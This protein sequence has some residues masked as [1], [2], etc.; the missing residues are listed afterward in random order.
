M[1]TPAIWDQGQWD[2]ASWD[3]LLVSGAITEGPDVVS[4]AVTVIYPVVGAITEGPDVVDG[5][6]TVIYPVVGNITEGEDQVVGYI[7]AG[8]AIYG[9]ITENPDTVAGVIKVPGRPGGGWAPQFTFRRE[10]EVIPEPIVEEA[11]EEAFEPDPEAVFI[12]TAPPLDPAVERIIRSIFQ[13]P[14]IVD[15]DD[16]DIEDI[17]MHL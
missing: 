12:A 4:G 13:G 9:E 17:L 5:Q 15:T 11:V 7:N 10:W 8:T 3:T 14:Q 6:I 16:D 2:D 1:T